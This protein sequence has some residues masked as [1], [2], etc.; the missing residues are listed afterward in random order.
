MNLFWMTLDSA[1]FLS[2]VMLTT[3][4]YGAV[5]FSLDVHALVLLFALACSSNKHMLALEAA[6]GLAPKSCVRMMMP[7]WPH[8]AVVW[9]MVVKAT[10]LMRHGKEDLGRVGAFRHSMLMGKETL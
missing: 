1:M 2:Q 6:L 8:L 7:C 9:A 10:Q 4:Q 5:Q 3:L